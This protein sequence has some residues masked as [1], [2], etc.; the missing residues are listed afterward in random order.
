MILREEKRDLFSVDDNEYYLVQCISA[1]FA[2]AAGIAVQFNDKYNLKNLLKDKFNDYIYNTY[3]ETR[4]ILCN[5]KVFNLITKLNHYE[6]PT[7]KSLEKCLYE[8][9]KMLL[10]PEYGIN[11]NKI[12]M[13]RIGCGLDRLKWDKVKMIIEKVFQDTNVEILVCNI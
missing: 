4:V 13:P 11:K 3:P 7:Y 2:M 12:A 1:D 6:K 9:K 5:N 10:N 8:M